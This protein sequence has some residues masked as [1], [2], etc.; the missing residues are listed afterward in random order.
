MH[1][2]YM[3]MVLSTKVIRNVYLNNIIYAIVV[4]LFFALKLSLK[5]TKY[6]KKISFQKKRPFDY[7]LSKIPQKIRIQISY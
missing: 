4:L 1:K 6:L 7:F 5:L 3:E 2:F